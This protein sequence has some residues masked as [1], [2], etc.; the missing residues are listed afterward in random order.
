MRRNTCLNEGTPP[1]CMPESPLNGKRT[2]EILVKKPSLL[3]KRKETQKEEEGYLGVDLPALKRCA[4]R[5][6]NS[7]CCYKNGRMRVKII[8]NKSMEVQQEKDKAEIETHKSDF[9]DSIEVEVPVKTKNKPTKPEVDILD[10]NALD[11]KLRG[12][13]GIRIVEVGDRVFEWYKE[14]AK[15][16]GITGKYNPSDYAVKMEVVLEMPVKDGRE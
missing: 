6:D 9:R 1:L 14:Q 10:S 12:P 11:K 13:S 7:R 2:K 15:N 5:E 3:D 4:S 16:K 8:E